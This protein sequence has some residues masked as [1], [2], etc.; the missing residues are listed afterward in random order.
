MHVIHFRHEQPTQRPLAQLC[1]NHVKQRIPAQHKT[2]YRS[3]AR[4]GNGVLHRPQTRQVQRR[5]LL[6]Q[7]VLPGLGGGNRVLRMQIVRR[8]DH[9]DIHVI[10]TQHRVQIRRD[11]RVPYDLSPA[12]P[13]RL[14]QRADSKS[15]PPAPAHPPQTPAHA[16]A[17]THPA[18]CTATPYICTVK[19]LA[20]SRR[21]YSPA[22][23]VIPASSAGTQ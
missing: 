16:P 8:T 21:V 20:T 22:L 4:R 18:P 2:H 6:N 19:P 7:H 12:Q 9:Q 3:Y 17:A 1:A 10:A 23:F 14:I 13:G 11:H 5:R 15:Q